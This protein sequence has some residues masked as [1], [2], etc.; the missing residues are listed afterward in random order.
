MRLFTAI[1]LPAP[2]ISALSTL[3]GSLAGV[4]WNRPNSYH[5]TLRFIGEVR[6]YTLMNDIDLAL[7]RI[8]ASAFDITVQN[9][10][11]FDQAN[12]HTILWAGVAPC[13]ALEHLNRKVEQALRN[14][15]LP[16]PRK[17]FYPH[18]TLARA[19]NIHNDK[20]AQWVQTYNLFSLP[21]TRITQFSL[22]SS[23][24]LEDNPYY[25]PEVDYLLY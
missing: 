13:K 9:V 19:Q 15:D 23:H 3:Q 2:I 14:L 12:Q 11:I 17:R 8:D 5:L 16:M 18:I 24:S 20:L 4:T 22:F 7:R 25:I 21:P 1:A 6:N 10:G